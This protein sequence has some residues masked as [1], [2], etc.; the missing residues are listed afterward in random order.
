[1]TD[2]RRPTYDLS[3]IQRA[4]ATMTMT[5]AALIGAAEMGMT[6]ADME[7]TIRR[8]RRRDFYK[9]MTTHGDKHVWMDVY[10]GH[11]DGYDIYIKFVQDT[12]AEFVCTSFK[13]K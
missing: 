12:V 5:R 11:A 7:A 13:E 6:R 8:L 9:S 3:A 10:H 2:K 1:M 4:A